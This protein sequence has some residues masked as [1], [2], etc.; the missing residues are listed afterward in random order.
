MPLAEL[1]HLAF[2]PK[3][4]FS[5]A[6]FPIRGIPGY[7]LSLRKKK[8]SDATKSTA[9]LEMARPVPLPKR[10]RAGMIK[11]NVESAIAERVVEIDGVSR[12]LK[13]DK[14]FSYRG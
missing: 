2:A 1:I 4:V 13:K 3:L 9:M 14:L 10:A 11:L 12:Y 8:V 6:S 5:D 7:G